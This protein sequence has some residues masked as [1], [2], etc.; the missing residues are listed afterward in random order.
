MVASSRTRIVLI[1]LALATGCYGAASL[2]A[3]ATTLDR[4]DFPK[5]LTKGSPIAPAGPDW[6]GSRK[7]SPATVRGPATSRYGPV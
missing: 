2:V 1:I 6:L 3:E 7:A 5:G 4:P